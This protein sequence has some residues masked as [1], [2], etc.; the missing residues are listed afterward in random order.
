MSKTLRGVVPKSTAS[1]TDDRKK[2]FFREAAAHKVEKK[3]GEKWTENPIPMEDCYEAKN[4][5]QGSS[6]KPKCSK[7]NL[8]GGT[9]GKKRRTA[10]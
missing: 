8:G 2:D 4:V 6:R 9:E 3:R 1:A 10:T 7:S 5:K